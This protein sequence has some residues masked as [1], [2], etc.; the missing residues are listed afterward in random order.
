ME[1]E[2]LNDSESCP[3][4][5]FQAPSRPWADAPVLSVLPCLLVN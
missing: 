5:W 1:E 2:V 3:G 4:L